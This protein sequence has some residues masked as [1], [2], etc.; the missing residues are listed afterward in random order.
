MRLASW[1]LI[2]YV[3]TLGLGRADAARPAD[4]A[5]FARALAHV[6]PGMT[7]AQ[8]RK[9]LGPP[10]DVRTEHDPGGISATRTTEIWRYGTSGHLTFATLGTVHLM[11]DGKVQYVFGG[12]GQPPRGFP[13]PELRH[14][15]GLIDAVPS[16]SAPLDPA[17]LIQAVNALQRLGKA[18]AL[19]A[20]DEYLRVSSPFDDDGREG[21][22]LLMRALFDVPPGGMPV[23]A[24]GAAATPT[25]PKALP[26]FPLVLVDDVPLKLVSGY[27]VGGMPERPETDVAAFRKV[28]TLRAHP[29]APSPAAL[30]RIEAYVAGPLGKAF[31]VDDTLRA[32]LYNQAL[33]LMAT[34]SRPPDATGATFFPYGPD[35]ARRWAARRTAV[36]ALHP[37][38]DAKRSRFTRADGSVRSTAVTRYARVWWDVPLRG[39]RH[40]RITFE[41]SDP[42]HVGIE[43]RIE[44]V[45]GK[46][47]AADTMRLVDP[48]TGKVLQ[49]IPIPTLA[50]GESVRG[51]Q[52]VLPAGHAL[53]PMLASGARGPA[54]TP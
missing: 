40:A 32:S 38:W 20:V 23:M 42:T 15:L 26:R 11:A 14:L 34:V 52:V 49:T 39:A 4:R 31:P 21:V 53:R 44:S 35:V 28:G 16:Y 17:R 1:V 33:R 47:Q 37:A 3:W 48:Q 30:A 41:R 51:S 36:E 2:V 50:P 12:R 43:L 25:D 5:A 18:R 7:A 9:V 46:P 6:H 54:L 27:V 19:A 45:L 8:V 22:F 13:E 29:L 10:D 24:V